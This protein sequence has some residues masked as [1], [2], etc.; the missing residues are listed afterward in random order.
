VAAAHITQSDGP[1]VG[2]SWFWLSPR[3]A[4]YLTATLHPP[5]HTVTD[6]SIG[7]AKHDPLYF[8]SMHLEQRLN[9]VGCNMME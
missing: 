9:S 2:A 5:R 7:Q 6:V 8:T 1:W 3:M 4:L